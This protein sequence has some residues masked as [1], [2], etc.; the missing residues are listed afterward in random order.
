MKTTIFVFL[1][2]AIAFLYSC[3]NAQ[4]STDFKFIGTSRG[5]CA[6]GNQPQ[7]QTQVVKPD[8]IYY[9]FDN[10]DLIIHVGF[11]MSCCILYDDNAQI[12]G[13]KINMNI[14][15]LKSDPCDCIC[16]YEFN[17][18]FRNYSK[19][20]YLYTV[21]IDGITKFDGVIDIQ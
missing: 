9:T 16:Y 4:E 20:Q 14:T 12:E 13:N 8:T 6:D 2:I 17:F 5:G 1:T 19:K 10:S 15:Q 11:T 21:K 7:M 18:K 3:N